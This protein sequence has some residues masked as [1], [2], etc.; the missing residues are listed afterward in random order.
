MRVSFRRAII[1]GMVGGLLCPLVG[2]AGAQFGSANAGGFGA[3]YGYESGGI[4]G[5]SGYGYESG[6]MSGSSTGGAATTDQDSAVA[7]DRTEYTAESTGQQVQHQQMEGQKPPVPSAKELGRLTD[8]QLQSLI[9]Q[10]ADSF[11]SELGQFHNGDTWAKYFR[12]DDLKALASPA[13]GEA[14][15]TQTS[16]I[17]SSQERKVVD[18]VLSR[19]DSTEKNSEYRAVTSIWGF[20]ALHA[21]LKEAARSPEER[22][23]GVLKAQA[24]ALDKSL[25]RISTGEGWRKHL[26]LDSLTKMADKKNLRSSE[27]AQRIEG[28]FDEVMRNP[29]YQAIVR[30]PGFSGVYATLHKITE[31]KQIPSTAKK[32]S[33]SEKKSTR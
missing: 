7:Y 31:G 30:L 13:A 26:E 32:E 4:R 17:S 3:S 8:Q 21:A 12:L 10:V 14:A 2:A 20:R 6:G 33:A 11:T 25:E 23:P 22:E 5:G 27:D 16:N 18:A 19:I 28:R 1:L 9:A 24:E 29:E 15:M